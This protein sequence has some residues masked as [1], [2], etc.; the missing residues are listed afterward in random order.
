MFSHKFF[1][2]SQNF[3]GF[4]LD[5]MGFLPHTEKTGTD[6]TTLLCVANTKLTDNPVSQYRQLNSLSVGFPYLHSFVI[7]SIVNSASNGYYKSQICQWP[8]LCAG[9]QQPFSELL[10]LSMHNNNIFRVGFF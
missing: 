4:S 6:R 9:R 3:I 8:Y 7:N 5:F 10:R 2:F 1:W